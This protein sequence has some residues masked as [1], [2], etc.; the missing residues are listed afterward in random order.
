[1]LHFA[2]RVLSRHLGL[3]LA[4]AGAILVRFGER[5]DASVCAEGIESADDLLVLA[6]LGVNYGQGYLLARPGF[7][8][9]EPAPDACSAL[10]RVAA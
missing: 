2:H 1:V 6:R 7:G 5:T 9:P 8:W 3:W 10:H 4:L